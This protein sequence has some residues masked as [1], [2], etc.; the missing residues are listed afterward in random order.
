MTRSIGATSGHLSLVFAYRL[1]HAHVES[2]ADVAPERSTLGDLVHLL[3]VHVGLAVVRVTIVSTL[4]L[5]AHAGL[6]V[7]ETPARAFTLGE[8]F[9]ARVADTELTARILRRV[10]PL[11]I[12]ETLTVICGQEKTLEY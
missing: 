3:A 4:G 11:R 12:V 10:D 6:F 8:Q 7:E 2:V 9:T 1:V 5:H